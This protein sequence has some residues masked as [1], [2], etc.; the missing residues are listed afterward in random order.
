MLGEGRGFEIAQGRLGPGRI[1]HC[2]RSIGVAERALEAMIE[3]AEAR[4]AF[5]T[6]LAEKGTVR[7]AIAR[8]RI[9][10]E[11]AR[12][13][14]LNAA[15]LMDTVGNKAARKEIAMIKVVAPRVALDVIDRAMQVHGAA[16][17]SDD[18]FL[19][20]AYAGQRTLR[21]ADGPDEVHLESIAK[22]ELGPGPRAPVSALSGPLPRLRR[23][24]AMVRARRVCAAARRNTMTN[25]IRA[26]LMGAL[27]TVPL[28]G[29][30]LA[31]EHARRLRRLDGDD[32]LPR[33]PCRRSRHR[34]AGERED[35]AGLQAGRRHDEVQAQDDGRHDRPASRRSV[36]DLDG[37][38][39]AVSVYQK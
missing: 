13:L 31:A 19:A 30:A 23:G 22:L 34:D 10:I 7:E 17:V 28:A 29:P 14:T 2:M 15:H 12:L 36:A 25:L 16:G 35:G 32:G 1:H 20:K 6:P 37:N 39:F 4:V 3:R 21:L 18:F 11:Q 24:G 27:V 33:R 9:E 5:G 38:V 26:A 8:S